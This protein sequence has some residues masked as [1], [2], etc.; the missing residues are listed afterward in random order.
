M[1][2]Q[3]PDT[4]EGR[5]RATLEHPHGEEYPGQY[6]YERKLLMDASDNPSEIEERYGSTQDQINTRRERKT[7]Q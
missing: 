1:Y 3:Y 5:A 4:P 2:P 7:N 6:D